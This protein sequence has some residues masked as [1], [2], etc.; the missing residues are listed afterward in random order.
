MIVRF[1]ETEIMQIME[2]HLREMIMPE[3][4]YEIESA[5]M[6]ALDG[7]SEPMNIDS[8]AYEIEIK[9]ISVESAR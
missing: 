9:P 2:A 4:E 8:Y 5:N 3:G 1:N 7:S 6:I